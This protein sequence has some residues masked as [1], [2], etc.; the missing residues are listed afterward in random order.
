MA[1]MRYEKGRKDETRRRILDVAAR[2]FRKEGVAA[3]GLAGVMADA[4]LTNGAFYAHFKSKDDLVREVLRDT[5]G[6]RH[7]ALG[8]QVA[9]D[10]IEAMLRSYLSP[11][12]RDN[13]GTGCPT[14]ALVGEVAR[15]PRA[16]REAFTNRATAL[17]DRM[18]AM[19]PDGDPEMRRRTAM[20]LYGTMVGTLQVA[21]A[22]SDR[23]LSDEILKAGLEAALRIA[24]VEA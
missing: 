15:Q 14:A 4:G 9:G 22:V 24:G 16:T 18:A 13:A 11:Y 17:F 3:A 8:K 6:Q 5:L 19:L 1:V 12:H 7:A 23:K 10:G 21:R 20:S 2:R